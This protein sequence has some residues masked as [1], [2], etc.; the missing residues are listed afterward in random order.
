MK[1]R[2]SRCVA[3]YVVRLLSSGNRLKLTKCSGKLLIA[4]KRVRN[5]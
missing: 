5:G 1:V 3:L 2:S 4:V